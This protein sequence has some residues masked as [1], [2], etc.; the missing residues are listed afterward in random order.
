[1]L[2]TLVLGAHRY[3]Y[4]G[5]RIVNPQCRARPIAAASAGGAMA[6]E[7]RCFRSRAYV[8][9]LRSAHCMTE[10]DGS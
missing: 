8:E 6:E 2:W 10:A 3:G 1:M 7:A 4:C 9:V 5:G